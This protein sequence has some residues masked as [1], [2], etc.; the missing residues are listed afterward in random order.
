MFDNTEDTGRFV[1][2]CPRWQRCCH[3]SFLMVDSKDSLFHWRAKIR[4]TTRE[5]RSGPF[6][7]IIR[8][9]VHFKPVAKMWANAASVRRMCWRYLI[10]KNSRGLVL[11]YLELLAFLEVQ[12]RTPPSKDLPAKVLIPP[13]DLLSGRWSEASQVE[14]LQDYCQTSITDA[15]Q[16]VMIVLRLLT[17]RVDLSRQRF[18]VKQAQ[19]WGVE[20]LGRIWVV[21]GRWKLLTRPCSAYHVVAG[22]YLRTLDTFSADI[23]TRQPDGVLASKIATLYFR[24][25]VGLLQLCL[26]GPYPSLEKDLSASLAELLRLPRTSTFVHALGEIMLPNL[27]ELTGDQPRTQPLAREIQVDMPGT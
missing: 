10:R 9:T 6:D 18:N 11:I 17:V 1:S 2:G 13:L 15:A 19:S 5:V 26:T 16:A 4:N 20:C 22:S 12:G 8:R 23:T 14:Y 21:L 24:S 27:R 7:S 3:P 25:V